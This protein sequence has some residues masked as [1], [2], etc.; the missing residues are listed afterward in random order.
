ICKLPPNGQG[1]TALIALNILECFDLAALADDAASVAH[2]QIEAVK[3]AFA[4][5]NRYI[6]D[7]AQAAVPVAQLLSKDYAQGRAALID[8]QRARKRINPAHLA[9]GETGHRTG[10]DGAGNIV[11]LINSLYLAFGSGI[12]AGDTGIVLQN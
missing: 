10:A 6:A 1:L 9:G 12:T 11:S 3:L 4:D 2:L 7:P 8:R 5:R